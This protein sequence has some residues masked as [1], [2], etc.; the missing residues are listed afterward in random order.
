MTGTPRIKSR[1]ERTQELLWWIVE[2]TSR[3]TGEEFF[4]S[5]VRS[6]AVALDLKYV[7]ITECLD[8]PVTRVRTLARWNGSGLA[9]N[10]EYNLAGQPCEETIRDNRVCFYP[11]RLADVFES[12]R[13]TDRVSYCGIPI[14][15]SSG[16]RVIGHFAFFDDKQ[17]ESTVFENPI[18]HI[19]AS[20]AAAE[21]QRKRAE[22]DS[23]RR[24]QLLA[25]ANRV[26]TAGELASAIAHEVNQPLTAI[27]TYAQAALRVIEGDLRMPV[28]VVDALKGIAAQA[29]RAADITRRLRSFV[30]DTEPHMEA[31]DLTVAAG[32]AVAMME[33][34]ARERRIGLHLRTGGAPLMVNADALQVEQVLINLLRNAFDAQ[35]GMHG[36]RIDL[37]CSLIPGAA[38]VEVCDNGPGIPADTAVRVFDAFY[39]TKPSGVG[40]GLAL[41][42]TIAQAF[43]G[44]LVLDS[45][46]APGARFVLRLPLLAR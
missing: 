34:E 2:A 9:Q 38:E 32:N 7:F 40:I 33:A 4:N 5:L 46:H 1:D 44:S 12:K 39:T 11:D 30:R 18:F 43:G 17:M 27:T 35:A 45:G 19:F 28:G 31:V 14:L 41:S 10:V 26:G 42:R 6:L 37:A 3:T 24:L 13:G 15:D 29:G 25:H 8:Q 21:V 23:H 20:R 36:A 16:Q 22:A